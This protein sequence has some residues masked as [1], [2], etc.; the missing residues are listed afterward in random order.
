MINS[1]RKEDTTTN[2]VITPIKYIKNIYWNYKGNARTG[3]EFAIR[4]RR[5]RKILYRE[6]ERVTE[7]ERDIDREKNRFDL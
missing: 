4:E 1:E 3:G 2:S 6:K 7:R 5:E